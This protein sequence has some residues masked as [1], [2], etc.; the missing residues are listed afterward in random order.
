MY[1]AFL[2]EF[3]H[4][5]P[6]ISR[7]DLSYNQSPVFGLSGYI[8]PHTE[9]RAFSTFFFQIKG[10][11]LAK[12][13]KQVQVHPATWE[14]KGN[15][16]FTNKNINKYQKLGEGLNRLI[17]RLVQSGGKFFYYGREKYQSPDKPNATG[18]YTTVLSHAIRQADN[19]VGSK[20]TQFFMILDQHS[21]RIR[22]LEASAKTMF[23]STP[24]RALI[25]PPFQVESHL[26][27]TIQAADW[28]ASITGKALAHRVSPDQFPD[29]AWAAAL[30]T[31][32]MERY[33]THSVLWRPRRHGAPNSGE[34]R[35]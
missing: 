35:S 19:Y 20:N 23:G 32:D 12:E 34:A 26:Y 30:F 22:L 1:I 15:E 28:I 24:A 14:K 16:L 10:W 31:D 17:N 33:S 7:K 3:G 4:I 13:L 21:D 29:W 9:A 6:Y 27:Q 18:L 8:I 5:G 25:E 11:M 2:D